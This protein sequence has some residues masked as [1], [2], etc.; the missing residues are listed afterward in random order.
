VFPGDTTQF[1]TGGS[2]A[3][4][5]YGLAPAE[6]GQY[7]LEYFHEPQFR[8]TLQPFGYDAPDDRLNY[9]THFTTLFL[10]SHPESATSR[11]IIAENRLAP[12]EGGVG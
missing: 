9:A 1:L 6:Q 12:L 4:T 10:H 5:P 11:R 7:A 2:V 3:S 8:A